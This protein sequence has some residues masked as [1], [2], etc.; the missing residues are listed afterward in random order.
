MFGYF[1]FSAGIVIA[2]SLCYLSVWDLD[3]VFFF[4]TLFSLVNADCWLTNMNALDCLSAFK[5]FSR[6]LFHDHHHFPFRFWFWFVFFRVCR[7]SNV[8][9]RCSQYTTLSYSKWSRM[10][11]MSLRLASINRHLWFFWPFA[12][13]PMKN[14]PHPNAPTIA[15]HHLYSFCRK[16]KEKML[17]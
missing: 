6:F 9:V 8:R 13:C 3:F 16:A 4:C 12:K 15:S 1:F 10:L 11:S 2:V 7:V 14:V 5:M 17:F